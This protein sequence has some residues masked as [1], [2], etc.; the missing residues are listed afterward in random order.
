[1]IC[2]QYK[3]IFIHQRKNAGSSIIRSFGFSP[4][5]KQWHLFNDGTMSPEWKRHRDA[6]RKNYLVF[7]VVRNPWDRFISGWKYLPD[8]KDKN[9]DD[10]MSD[11]PR[12]GHDYRHLTRPQMDILRDEDGRFVPDV[13]LRFENLEE[14]YRALCQRLGKPFNLPRL[15]V[16]G[17]AGLGEY[18]TRAQVDFI[19]HHFRR[20]VEFFGYRFEGELPAPDRKRETTDAGRTGA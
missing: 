19:G 13:V 15:N 16:T 7:T 12:E 8:F 10:V 5:Q 9:L 1:V 6:I 4:R 14:D 11:L 18:R 17:H 20:D 2:N 3:C